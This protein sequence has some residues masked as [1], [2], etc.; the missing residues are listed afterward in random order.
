MP[1]DAILFRYRC[2]DVWVTTMSGA[3][4]IA[5]VIAGVTVAFALYAVRSESGKVQSAS[6]VLATVNVVVA[7]WAITAAISSMLNTG[8]NV[9][10]AVSSAILAACIA[11]MMSYKTEIARTRHLFWQEP[12]E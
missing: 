8:P 12:G 11:G 7:A 2:K 1:N 5:L 3:N 6:I 4:I 10:I 9:F